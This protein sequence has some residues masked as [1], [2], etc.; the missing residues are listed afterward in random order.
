MKTICLRLVILYCLLIS[1]ACTTPPPHPILRIETG[2]HTA[3]IEHISL[4]ASNRILATCSRDKTV[5]IWNLSNGNLVST[6]HPPIGAGREGMIF[7]AALSP[8]SSIVAMGGITGST[9]DHYEFYSVYLFNRM[10]GQMVRR[11][12]GLP[13]IIYHLKF[14]P[15]GNHLAVL[16]KKGGLRVYSM[17]TKS[18]DAEFIDP[19]YS[20]DCTGLDFDLNG[21]IA[22]SCVGGAIRLYDSAFKMVAKKDGW[23]NNI[24]A[25]DVSFSPDG[26]KL[27]VGYD[28]T[29]ASVSVLSGDDL[30]PLFSP[31]T[32]GINGT[33]LA[34]V[35]WSRDGSRLCAG[36]SWQAG[37]TTKI[38]CWNNGGQGGYQDMA[39]Q[40]KEL[41]D[42][43]A[44]PNNR[45][46]FATDTPSWGILNPEGQGEY[47][48]PSYSANF[49][50]NPNGLLISKDGGKIRFNYKHDGLPTTFSLEKR[51][52]R[53]EK[54]AETALEPPHTTATK[55]ILTGW[56]AT[57][58]LQVGGKDLP[59]GKYVGDYLHL[60]IAH[61]GDWFVV[62]TSR[63]LFCFDRSGKEHWR[64]P[65]PGETQAVNI[66]GDDRLVVAAFNDGTI[67][68]YRSNQGLERLAFFPHADNQRWVAWTPTGQYD[69][70]P[71]A[72]NLVSWHINQGLDKSPQ[73]F[74]A[75]NFADRYHRA[76]VVAR[77]LQ[78]NVR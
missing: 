48:Q 4:D 47:L 42:L 75:S 76:E 74:P 57:K 51:T 21:R 36:G 46:L 70:S 15:D 65:V 44:L 23:N 29:F 78:H 72:E 52:L 12:D 63:A 30:H 67:R 35:T 69:T 50:Q 28:E 58:K 1:G 38:R 45:L 55:F 3:G 8:D 31:D 11:F 62:G 56:P 60:A 13:N 40:G 9:L 25:Y 66:S 41:K 14:S 33:G 53:L 71:G 43:V 61:S 27:A 7:A 49:H 22:T 37:D 20:A 16:L 2:M 17:K 64:V 18:V 73:I 5:R 59:L 54:D 24:E 68:W 10:T 32:T 39:V 6:L 77:S 19:N 26:K 34:K